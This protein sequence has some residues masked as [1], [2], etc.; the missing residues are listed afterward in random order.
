MPKKKAPRKISIRLRIVPLALLK[1][2]FAAAQMATAK[3]ETDHKGRKLSNEDGM[4]HR[5][6]VAAELDAT[7]RVSDES[8]RHG[9]LKPLTDF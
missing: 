4:E 8:I 9:Q 7:V 5:R 1:K 2:R 3:F 6:L